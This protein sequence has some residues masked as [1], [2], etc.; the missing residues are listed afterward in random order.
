M[1][2]LLWGVLVGLG[3]LLSLVLGIRQNKK[4][5]KEEGA[6]NGVFGDLLIS[7]IL[8]EGLIWILE[9]LPYWVTRLLFLLIAVF[10][11]YWSY[12]LITN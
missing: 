7:A 3:G 9:K 6:A 5:H 2:K 8:I 10:C 12:R 4:I 1:K 11:F